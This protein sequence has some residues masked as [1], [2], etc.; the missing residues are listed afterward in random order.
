M[1]NNRFWRQLDICSPEKLTFPITVIGAGAIGS[2][3]VLTLTKMGCSNVTV[4]DEDVLSEHNIPN[5]MALVQYVG[6]PKVDALAHL[7]E[8]L[9]EVKIRPL[10]S[11]YRGQRLEGVVISAVDSMS[12]RKMIWSSVKL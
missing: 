12:A 11:N 5:Q 7:V 6:S 8:S 3:T 10:S 2:A 9:S 4:Y 1:E